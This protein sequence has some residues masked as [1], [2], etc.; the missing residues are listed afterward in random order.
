MLGK[1]FPYFHLFSLNSSD[2][3]LRPSADQLLKHSFI[4]QNEAGVNPWEMQKKNCCGHPGGL[5]D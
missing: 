3:R 2:Q 5:C 4:P 1:N